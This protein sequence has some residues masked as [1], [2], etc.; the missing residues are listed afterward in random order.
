[1]ETQNFF[2]IGDSATLKLDPKKE[3]I[4]QVADVEHDTIKLLYWNRAKQEI[5]ATNYLSYKLFDKVD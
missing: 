3:V 2:E 4:F 5:V 1:M